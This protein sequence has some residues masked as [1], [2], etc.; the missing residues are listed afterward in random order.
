[1]ANKASS[2]GRQQK[3][4]LVKAKISPAG[5]KQGFTRSSPIAKSSSALK[6]K[7]GTSSVSG[8][9]ISVCV[10]PFHESVISSNLI[11]FVSNMI[12]TESD[13]NRG[14]Q[15]RTGH[16]P[17]QPKKRV[18][19]VIPNHR[20]RMDLILD[21]V[22]T[23]DVLLCVFPTHATY[24]E[25]CFD[26]VGYEVLKALRMQGLP[27]LV[28]GSI[29]APAESGGKIGVKTVE[30]YFNSEF[31]TD[32]AKFVFPSAN[33]TSLPELA[34]QVMT[35][36]HTSLSGGSALKTDSLALRRTRGYMLIDSIS[37][38][39]SGEEIVIS[40]F[41]RGAGFGLQSV[42]HLTG[43]AENFQVK[44]LE[45]VDDE[46]V[47]E[48]SEAE[49]EQGR[50]MLEPLRPAEEQEQTWPT[51][52][53]EAM[54]EML[55][56]KMKKV[57]VPAGASSDMEA[58]WL[59]QDMD[60]NIVEEHEE[61]EIGDDELE[62]GMFD[63]DKLGGD[64]PPVASLSEKFEHR[65]REDMDFPDEVDTPENISARVRFQKYRGLKSLRSGNWDPYE[66]LPMEYSQIHEF[67]DMGWANKETIR[68]LEESGKEARN[69]YVRLT[70]VPQS[71]R[72]PIVVPDCLV[73]ST[74]APFETKV[75]LVHC[76]VARVPESDD[77]QIHNKQLVTVQVGF[78]RFQ[79]EPTFSEIPKYSSST[80]SA[81]LQKMMRV[82]PPSATNVLMSFYAPAVLGGSTPVLAFSEN[83][84]LIFWG[85]LQ[86]CHPN[87]PVIVKRSTLTGYPFRV[88]QTKAVCRF[89]FF[90]PA[91]IDWFKPV[92]LSTK[93]GL[94]GHIIESLGTHGYMK[95]RFNG[96]LTSDDILCL[97]LYKRVFPRWH[98]AGSWEPSTQ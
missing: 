21:S 68:H 61:E 57:A 64:L 90:D 47:L 36:I 5:P 96:Q 56:R 76:R 1:M 33:V 75:T 39:T 81:P 25:S 43:Y 94:R 54:A 19:L 72:G 77:V 60:Y 8:V 38:S 95:C 6:K 17:N 9:P 58:A 97:N 67:Q 42:V 69:V 93:K 46:M 92:E 74:V 16:I 28:V 55:Q 98:P 2:K 32:K 7:S 35:C 15:I 63:W 29:I 79:V 86:S 13:V 48:Q 78:R 34:R 37:S 45:I 80:G 70:L 52:E 20:D 26:Q 73:A 88:H 91:D 87:K 18:Q 4:K 41:S 40:G 82:V 85:S 44:R 30:R 53:E 65:E 83:S 62:A 14:V 24:E 66:E 10:V 49:L 50:Q 59:G 84:R 51:A 89:M 71:R 22:K 11:E 12:V 3:S 27:P 23:A 31:A